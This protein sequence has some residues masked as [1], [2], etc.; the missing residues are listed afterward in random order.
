MA[1][2]SCKKFLPTSKS[3]FYKIYQNWHFKHFS[4]IIVNNAVFMWVLLHS[5]R[6]GML[7]LG[8][9]GVCYSMKS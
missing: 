2:Y 7:N 1:N 4:K 5:S 3:L 6:H 8:R 9:S